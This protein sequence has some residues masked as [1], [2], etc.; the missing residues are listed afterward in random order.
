MYMPLPDNLDSGLESFELQPGQT[1][2]LSFHPNDR[3][4][5]FDLSLGAESIVSIETANDGTAL[6]HDTDLALFSGDPSILTPIA[7]NDDIEPSVNPYSRITS[8]LP[9]GQY[10]VSVTPKQGPNG[11]VTIPS[12]AESVSVLTPCDVSDPALQK[13]PGNGDFELLSLPC[14]PPAGTTINSLFNDDIEGEY[15]DGDSGTWVV[16]TWDPEA[17]DYVNPGP[18]GTL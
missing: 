8:T 17:F 13:T 7:T 10:E 12:Y 1:R 9:A 5:S 14:Q 15:F 18:N 3:V 11:P 16:F 6:D 4:D 2:F